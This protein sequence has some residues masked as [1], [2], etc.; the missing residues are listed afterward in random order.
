MIVP[1]LLLHMLNANANKGPKYVFG[2]LDVS[3]RN[4]DSGV[5]RA[6]K[7]QC[8]MRACTLAQ[9]IKLHIARTGA[10]LKRHV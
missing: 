8:A 3:Q 6:L 10:S 2:H 7:A 9:L 4:M 1:D 5:W